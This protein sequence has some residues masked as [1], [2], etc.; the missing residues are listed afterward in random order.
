MPVGVEAGRVFKVG[1]LHPQF[2]RPLVHLLHERLFAPG[3]R[4]GQHHRAVVGGV[5]RRRLDDIRK[6]HLLPRLQ[7]DLGPAHRSGVVGTADRLVK[8]NLPR[9]QRLEGQK[10][11]H[12]L[13]DRRRGHRFVGVF[14]IEDGIP[15]HEDAAPGRDIEGNGVCRPAGRLFR[16]RGRYTKR[17]NP[18]RYYQRRQPPGPLPPPLCHLLHTPFF[19]ESICGQGSFYASVK[20]IPSGCVKGEIAPSG[21]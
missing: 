9:L 12:N 13:G 11:G 1:V 8:G 4:L 20:G 10:Q 19:T 14:L 7:P 16:R 5:D 21:Q 15:R 18:R 3:D 2:G 17:I 6:G